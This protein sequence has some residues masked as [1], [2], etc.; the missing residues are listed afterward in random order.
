M[1]NAVLLSALAAGLA[2]GAALGVYAP[3]WLVGR[4]WGSASTALKFES[5]FDPTLLERLDGA[6]HPVEETGAAYSEG[7]GH[8]GMLVKHPRGH[9]EAVHDPRSDGDSRGI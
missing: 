7:F 8:A 1:K 5:R 4:T 6:G 9:V 2:V 3:R